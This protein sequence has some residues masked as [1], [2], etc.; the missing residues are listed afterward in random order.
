MG[1]LVAIVGRPNVGKSTLFNRLIERREA[2]VDSVAGVTRDR[3]YGRSE[4]CGV[5]FGVVD[6]GG[7]VEGSDD[8]FEEEIRK[9]VEFSIK[10]AQVILFLVDVAEGITD[11][12]QEIALLLRKS[13]KKVVVVVN[14]VDS[15]K[16][17]PDAVEFYAL[18]LGDYFCISGNNGMG[19]GELLD[20]VVTLFNDSEEEDL[21]HLPKIAIVGQ[22]NVGKSSLLN[23]LVGADRAI[24]TPIAGTTRDVLHSHYK[25]FGHEFLLVDTAGLRRKAKVK[26]D[27]EFYSVMRT[28]RAIESA[29]VCILMIEATMGL[30]AQDLSIF[31]LM[32]KNKKGVVILVNKWDLIE[33][34]DTMSTKRF[35]ES[36]VERIRPFT[37]VPI[38]FT[39]V[40]EK[41]RIH[42]AI[43]VAIEVYNNRIKKIPTSKL[44]NVLLPLI[45]A[46]PPPA[47]RGRLIK[48]K[49]ITQLP[50]HTPNFAFFCNHPKDVKEAYKR[51]LENKIREHFDFSGVPI[52]IIFRDKND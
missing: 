48:I 46:F 30:E 18:G 28:V 51:F 9:Q 17:M 12:D 50:T 29:D 24:V 42:K 22:P 40:L 16:R 1:N 49:Y 5:P 32:E 33:Q 13:N 47:N 19:T 20:H 31:S 4:W 23:L 15:S 7:Y 38:V 37:D 3:H 34:K 26:E 6:T 35:T 52:G 10:E 8:V 44:N 45:S 43:E 21:S 14:K 11:L 39:S 2:I 27:I 25:G 36:I 41:Q